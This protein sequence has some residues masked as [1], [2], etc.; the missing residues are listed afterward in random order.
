MKKNYV[1]L[2][3][4]L[5]GLMGCGK[6]SKTVDGA[7]CEPTDV[8]SSPRAS[9]ADTALVL[10][11]WPASFRQSAKF[12]VV[13]RDGKVFELTQQYGPDGNSVYR[14]SSDGD[15]VL[16]KDFRIIENITMKNKINA[17]SR[18]K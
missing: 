17:F 3:L 8:T 15:T 16:V 1:A 13:D 14:F 10:R 2:M 5:M 7:P 6:N 4:A 9:R 12:L 18:Q 11:A